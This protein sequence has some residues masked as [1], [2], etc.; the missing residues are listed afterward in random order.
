MPID[1]RWSFEQVLDYSF[2][3]YI[4]S[5]LRSRGYRNNILKSWG[6]MVGRE[7]AVSALDSFVQRLGGWESAAEDIGVS[8]GTL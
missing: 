8:A 5:G 3:R 6:D 2:Q 7:R 4:G 1:Y